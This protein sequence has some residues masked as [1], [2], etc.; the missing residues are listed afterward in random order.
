ML[1]P[2][3]ARVVAN[4]RC[5][6]SFLRVGPSR[7][8]AASSALQAGRHVGPTHPLRGGSACTV[9]GTGP[10]GPHRRFQRRSPSLPSR[11]SRRFGKPGA[12]RVGGVSR[13]PVVR[14]SRP[15]P[16]SLF[17][18][19]SSD[20]GARLALGRSVSSGLCSVWATRCR[21]RPDGAWAVPGG[22]TCRCN[23]GRV[24]SFGWDTRGRAGVLAIFSGAA[25]RRCARLLC[26]LCSVEFGAVYQ[27]R[28]DDAAGPTFPGTPRTSRCGAFAGG[29]PTPM[30]CTR[31]VRKHVTRSSCPGACSHRGQ[32]WPGAAVS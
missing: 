17:H 15:A 3:T 13:S 1:V 27:L 19:R 10:T 24:V 31:D 25:R 8:P 32:R 28:C 2:P 26:W 12:A 16:P 18:L 9:R 23:V 7:H 22:W 20:A 21:A 4:A 14:P 29:S 6:T 5:A 11:S 30:P